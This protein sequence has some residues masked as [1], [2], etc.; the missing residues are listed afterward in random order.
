MNELPTVCTLSPDALAARREDLLAALRERCE[1]VERT[2]S[3]CRLQFAASSETL[4]TLARIVD[5]ERQCCQFLEFRLTVSP[6][7]GPMTLEVMGPEG[8]VEFLGE[9]GLGVPGSEVPGSDA[10]LGT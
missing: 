4:Q 1:R 2:P 5:A 10:N 6:G 7:L 8:T 9:L 3:G